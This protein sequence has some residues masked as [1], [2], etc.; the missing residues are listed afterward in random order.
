MDL[1]NLDDVDYFNEYPEKLN[2]KFS[3]FLIT[4]LKTLN[5]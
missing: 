4:L 3:I 5:E 2:D 1:N